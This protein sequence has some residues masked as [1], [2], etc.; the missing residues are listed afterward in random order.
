MIETLN[1][2][3][4][5]CTIIFFSLFTVPY[6]FGYGID[7]CIQFFVMGTAFL[8]VVYGVYNIFCYFLEYTDD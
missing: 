3:A 6:F 7:E 5:I 1:K 2:K 4:L 8:A